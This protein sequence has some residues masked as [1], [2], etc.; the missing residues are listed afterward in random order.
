MTEKYREL[1]LSVRVVCA[2]STAI[3]MITTTMTTQP[4]VVLAAFPKITVFQEDDH[5]ELWDACA[6]RWLLLLLPPPPLPI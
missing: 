5:T 2:M 4:A 6:I 3:V 1:Q